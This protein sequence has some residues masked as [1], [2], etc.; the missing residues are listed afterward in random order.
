M[1]MTPAVWGRGDTAPG[2]GERRLTGRDEA[3]AQARAVQPGVERAVAENTA[4]SA[5]AQQEQITHDDLFAGDRKSHLGM[6]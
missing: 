5:L 1:A 6:N 3:H 4:R 2:S